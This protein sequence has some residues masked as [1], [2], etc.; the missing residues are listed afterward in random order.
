[1]FKR[2]AVVIVVLFVSLSMVGISSAKEEIKGDAL[3]TLLTGK[4]I[5]GTSVKGY[6]FEKT[7]NE[8]GT[9]VFKRSTG[10]TGKGTWKIGKWGMLRQKNRKHGETIIKTYKI[11]ENSYEH[12]A[13]KRDM[14]KKV[15]TFMIVE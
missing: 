4:T 7:Y 1:M 2:F 13:E 6:Q 9:Y 5:N 3:A 12:Y 8:D 14:F 15:N 11:D 10:K